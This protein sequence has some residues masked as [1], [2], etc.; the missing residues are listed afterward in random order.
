LIFFRLEHNTQSKIFFF[1]HS[2]VYLSIKDLAIQP[3]NLTVSGIASLSVS[4]SR[5]KVQLK[6]KQGKKSF[7]LDESKQSSKQSQ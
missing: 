2:Q 3:F 5:F 1:H 6:M 7:F 4:L